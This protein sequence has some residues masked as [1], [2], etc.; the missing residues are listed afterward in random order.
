MEKKNAYFVYLQDV[1]FMYEGESE[2]SSSGYAVLTS[3][4][5]S[6]D[7]WLKLAV[8]LNES[9][10]LHDCDGGLEKLLADNVDDDCSGLSNYAIYNEI[11]GSYFDFKGNVQEEPYQNNHNLIDLR[12]IGQMTDDEFTIELSKLKMGVLKEVFVP[13]KMKIQIF[14]ENEFL[15]SK[16]GRLFQYELM[17]KYLTEQNT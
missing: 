5:P 8:L 11:K 14:P 9:N 15:M 4:K 3:D 16:E 13:F 2:G 7:S 12:T 17:K 10:F 6:Y 1:A